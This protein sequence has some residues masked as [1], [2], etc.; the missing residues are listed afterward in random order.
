MLTAFPVVAYD[1]DFTSHPHHTMLAIRPI[2]FGAP[3]SLVLTRGPANMMIK[4]GARAIVAPGGFRLTKASTVRRTFHSSSI[5]KHQPF[6]IT[7]GNST[8]ATINEPI[9]HS[10]FEPQT[11]TWQYIVADP[12]T[13]AAVIIDPVLD[14]DLARNAVSTTTADGLLATAEEQGYTVE[15]LLETHAHA[16]HLTAAAYLQ[17]R[18]EAMGNKKAGICIG[19][20]IVGVQERFAK[21]YGIEGPE[22][23]AA[24]DRLLEDDEVLRVGRL[25]VKVMHLPGH[26]PDHLG[27]LVGSNVFCG[28]SLFNTDVGTARCDFPSG[29][30]HQLYASA[31]KLFSLPDAFRI[32][33]GH[34]YVPPDSPRGPQACTTVA[35]QRSRNKHLRQ[36]TPEDQ[37]VDWRAKRDAGLGEPRLLHQAL[38]FNVRGGHLPWKTEG[39]DRFMKVPLKVAAAGWVDGKV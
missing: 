7:K 34:D 8:M 4:G 1:A 25:E 38:Q 5:L 13:K 21:R 11:S 36:D 24:F 19:K 16:D 10:V 22:Y 37:F 29:D 6:D 20:R 15:W 14:Y 17:H 23:R 2:A 9:I 31:Q 28:D 39:G 35:E 12:T 26:T 33:T 32:Y 30:V 18:L 27:Y 3:R